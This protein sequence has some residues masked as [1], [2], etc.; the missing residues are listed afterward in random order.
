MYLRLH[1]VLEL[2]RDPNGEAIAEELEPRSGVDDDAGEQGFRRSRS[3][4]LFGR[5]GYGGVLWGEGDDEERAD[6]ENGMSPRKRGIRV[7]SGE[8]RGF[9]EDGIG[10]RWVEREGEK[11]NGHG[12]TKDFFSASFMVAEILEARIMWGQGLWL[13]YAWKDGNG[14]DGF[15][16]FLD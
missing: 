10:V 14:K 2:R 1:N 12:R 3:R 7:R 6:F 16:I 4:S 5:T 11:K 13:L 9:G 15:G 8:R